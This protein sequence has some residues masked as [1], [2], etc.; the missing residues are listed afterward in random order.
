MRYKFLILLA[1][2]IVIGISIGWMDIR[3]N[4][5]DTGITVMIVLIG[6]AV[7]GFTMPPRAWVWAIVLGIWVPLFNII[8]NQNYGSA[9]ALVIAFTGSYIG[10]FT[11]KLF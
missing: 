5:D 8:I 10:A 3:P 2:A 7:L 6:S 11:R 1:A 4:W 9:V